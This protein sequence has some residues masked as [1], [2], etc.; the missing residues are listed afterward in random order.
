[1]RKH[2]I[3]TLAFSML[4]LIATGSLAHSDT[5][6]HYECSVIGLP[7]PEPIGDRPDHSLLTVEYSCVGIDGLL[8]GAVYTASN[9]VEWDGPKGTFL[10][11]GGMHRI[12]GGRAVMQMVEGT[13]SAVM[14]DGKLVGNQTSG[15][16]IV[17]FASGPF[18]ALSGKTIRFV[19]TPMNPVRFAIEFTD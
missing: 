5:I 12:P 15:K 13:A 6:A 2:L 3:P 9:T 14:K 16:T 1:M 17:K 18:A 8:K 4:G 7:G 10:V 11:G 19:T